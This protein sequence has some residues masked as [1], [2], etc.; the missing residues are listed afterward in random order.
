MDEHR[1]AGPTS[2]YTVS[3]GPVPE[4]QLRLTPRCT[5]KQLRINHTVNLHN[6]CHAP[7]TNPTNS[8]KT[9]LNPYE[10]IRTHSTQPHPAPIHALGAP[11]KT[12][13]RKGL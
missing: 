8:N 3:P 5:K 10:R 12:C 7:V 13:N 11:L 1:T 2:S 6:P 9:G 4:N